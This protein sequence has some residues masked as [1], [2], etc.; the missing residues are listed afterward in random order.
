MFQTFLMRKLRADQRLRTDYKEYAQ[1][2]RQIWC[3]NEFNQTIFTIIALILF[4]LVSWTSRGDI[5]HAH[6]LRI[7]PEL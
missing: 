2:T 1:Y 7:P 4:Y 6:S 3:L 5:G